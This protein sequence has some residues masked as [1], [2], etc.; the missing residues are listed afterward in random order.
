MISIV[1][2]PS[3]IPGP[4][5]EQV[6]VEVAGPGTTPGTVTNGRGKPVKYIVPREAFTRPVTIPGPDGKEKIPVGPAA[7]GTTPGT[8]TG[9]G[10]SVRKIYLPSTPS[11]PSGADER[12]FIFNT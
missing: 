6:P 12:N 3:S 8:E 10:G 9:P 2:T 5:N 11:S 7:P 4:D 1:S